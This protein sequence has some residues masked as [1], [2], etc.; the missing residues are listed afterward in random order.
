MKSLS[1]SLSALGLAALALASLLSCSPEPETSEHAQLVL[2]SETLSPSTTFELRFDEALVTPAVVGQSPQPSPLVIQPRLPGR[3]IWLSQRSGVFTPDQPTALGTTYRLTLQRGWKDAAGQPL[4]ARLHRTLRTP[5]FAVQHGWLGFNA[6]NVPLS[7]E[8]KLNFNAAVHPDTALPYLEFRDDAGLRIP[9]R[10]AHATEEDSFFANQ[11]DAGEVMVPWSAQ[12]PPTFQGPAPPPLPPFDSNQRTNLVLH[13]LIVWPQRPL[14]VGTGWKLAVAA[15]LPSAERALRL[16]SAHE[17]KLG[18]V[19]EF[20]LESATAHSAREEGKRIGIRFSKNL[21][22]DLTSSN[23]LDWISVQPT[24]TNL[25]ARRYQRT[26]ELAGAFRPDQSYTVSIR[27]GLLPEDG[28]SLARAWTN[29]VQFAPLPPRLYFPEFSTEQLAAGRREFE[30]VTVNTPSVRVRAKRLDRDTL[31]H[32]LRGYQSYFKHSSDHDWSEPYR[33]VDFNIVAG[34]TVFSE[35]IETAGAT[36]ESTR[37]PL[38]WDDILGP[39]QRGAVFL[40]AEQPPTEAHGRAAQGT[41][42]IVQITDLGL[43]WKTSENSATVHVFS[44]RTGQPVAQARVCLLTDENETIAERITDAQGLVS[45]PLQPSTN[46]LWL[47]AQSGDDLHAARLH[48][49]E[50]PL[51]NFGVRQDWNRA[52]RD[53]REVFLFT[54]RPLYRPGETVH[55]QGIL[56]DRDGET[57]SI[58]AGAKVTLRVT[59]PKEE[60]IFETNLVVSAAGSV[61]ASVPLPEG[62][63]GYYSLA[64]QSSGHTYSHSVQVADFQPNAFAVTLDSKPAYAA[65][66]EVRVPLQASYLMGAPLTR[67]KVAWSMEASDEGF[68]PKGFEDFAFTTEWLDHQ[69]N[70]NRSSCTAHGEG[71]YSSKSNFVIAPQIPFNPAAPQPR[72]IH[73]RAEVTDLNQQTITHSADAVAH[74]S[75]FYLGLGRSKNILRAGVPLPVELIAVRADGQPL[76]TPVDAKLSLLRVDHISVPIQSAGR[77]RRYHTETVVT[78][79]A[80]TTMTTSSVRKS[81]DKWEVV[82]GPNP[83]PSLVPDQPGYYLLEARALDAGRREVV[84]VTQFYIYGRS[85]DN[86]WSYRNEIQMDLVPDQASYL[87]GHTAAIL[88]KAPFTGHALV[89]VEREKVLRSFVTELTGTA[90]SVQVALQDLDAPNVFVSV[91]LL[92]GSADSPRKFKMPEYRL[93]YCELKVS[94][95]RSQLHF[96]IAPGA[97]DYRPAQTV[98]VSALITD[99]TG[100]P[101]RDT[102]V[103][104]YAVDEG[105]LGI[106]GHTTPDPHAFFFRSR[107]LGVGCALTLPSLFPEDPEQHSFANKGYLI[108]GGGG[109]G[110]R[111]RVRKNF[112]PCAYWNAALVT[113]DAGQV[114]ATFPAP[115]SL[116]RYRVIAVAHNAR[117]QFGSGQAHFE[118]NKPLMIESALP[119]FAHVTDQLTARGV[120]HNQTAERGVIEVTVQLDDKATTAGSTNNRSFTKRLPLRE[121]SSAPI[122]FPVEFT[123]AGSSRWTWSARFAEATNGVS[124]TSTPLA[125]PRF[126]D[127]AESTILVEHLAPMLRE[128]HLAHTEEAETNLLAAANPQ[129]LEGRGTIEIQV[130][131]SRLGEL[132][133]ALRYLLHYPYGCVEQTSSSLLP[134]IVLRQAP[135]LTPDLKKTPAEFDLAIRAGVQRLL[136]MQTASG[137]LSYWPGSRQPM[138]WG[139][140]YGGFVLALARRDHHVVTPVKFDRLMHYL[141]GALRGSATNHQEQIDISASCLALYTLALAGQAEPAYHEIFFNQRGQLSADNRALLALAISESGGPASMTAELLASPASAPRNETDWFRCDSRDLALQL[142]AWL[143]HRPHDQRIDLLVTELTHG[144]NQG[145]WS[146]T[147]GNAWAVFALKEYDVSVAGATL[148]ST[149]RL[150]WAA[151]E[152]SFQLPGRPEVFGTVLP[153]VREAA[154]APLTLVNPDRRRLYTQVTIEARP[155]LARAP[156]Q[157]RGFG[158]TRRYHR[159]DDDGKLQTP[160]TLR[161]GDRVLVTLTVDIHQPAHYLAVDDALPAVLEPLNPEFKSQETAPPI[162]TSPLPEREWQSDHH[163][164]RADRALF[165]RDHVYAAGRYEIRYLTRVRAAGTV[166]APA[167]KVEEMYHPEH[168]GLSEATPLTARPLE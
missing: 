116:T 161:V 84:T 155:A 120:V 22:P 95:P 44:H 121:K 10:T 63:R 90:P 43:A 66:S 72:S 33:E 77:A 168:F 160:D 140:A 27:A 11:W 164:F 4:N 71:A 31:I 25:T 39:G 110:G 79:L 101:A 92:R 54:D 130:A 32:A 6:G 152:K 117:H 105:I 106:T 124:P 129:L 133:E 61:A 7:P 100:Q 69:L 163:E 48:E 111:D 87:A 112:L 65:G 150:T 64:L 139:S 78:N 99:G 149:G 167:A 3:F 2:S 26:V 157:D 85:D 82:P 36:D 57:F 159:V 40:V 145:H 16:P 23:L 156:R 102:E 104:L 19:V 122:E 45:L 75:D 50:L 29:S 17:I 14:P 18:D 166:T 128:I 158:I 151:Q 135:T 12:L 107:P 153:I 143:R 46:T 38:D 96:A 154:R 13:R 137:G 80:T 109:S 21:S 141:S 131:N 59:D 113:D 41:Q 42:A 114:R 47:L 119:R 56:R 89:T 118:V 142:L 28:M 147:Q 55:C 70:R 24:P 134:W 9:V 68:D 165:F 8:I 81:G 127:A 138:F 35:L 125:S 86:A 76:S 58:P 103:V 148:S 67:A 88:V 15:G 62:V 20:L 132:G 146:T 51:Y 93:G 49:H 73:L 1:Q 34:R 74:S 144:R 37:V 94:D 60:K 91:L 136:S 162:D 30:L 108:G 83:P 53:K 97:S 123:E 115:D 5:E 98:S 126:T 52:E